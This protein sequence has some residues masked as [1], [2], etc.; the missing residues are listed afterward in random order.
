MSNPI[1][2]TR[3]ERFL[4]CPR[5][6]KFYQDGITQRPSNNWKVGSCCHEALEV[7]VDSLDRKNNRFTMTIDEAMAYSIEFVKPFKPG[8]VDHSMDI[9]KKWLSFNP[10]PEPRKIIATEMRFGPKGTKLRGKEL[11]EYIKFEN[12]LAVHGIVDILWEDDDG[13]IVIGD[14]KTSRQWL[15]NDE[16]GG[17]IQ[18]QLYAA[19]INNIMPER[20]CRVE[21]YMIR[22]PQNGPVVWVPEP[23]EFENIERNLRA[24]Q[25][26]VEREQNFEAEPSDFCKWCSYNYTCHAFKTWSSV[27]P[28]NSKLWENM[29][30]I[31]LSTELDNYFAKYIAT[32]KVVDNIKDLLQTH[33]DRDHLDQVGNWKVTR[34]SYKNYDDE[35]APLIAE[36]GGINKCPPEM[37][38]ELEDFKKTSWGRPFLKKVS[39]W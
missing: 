4:Q 6:F 33:M 20:K 1:S 13:T 3:L 28:K 30:L 17:K 16:L 5:S 37:R 29:G 14:Y 36:Y 34:K 31:E 23:Y 11:H 7:Y 22:Y 21:F 27:E 12:D 26:A 2:P 25:L 32:K 8:V 38:L 39:G 18:A 10:L 9:L 19:A 15:T 24:Y 35:V